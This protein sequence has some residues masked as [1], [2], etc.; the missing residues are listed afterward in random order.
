QPIQRGTKAQGGQVR[1]CQRF[2]D[3]RAMGVARVDQLEQQ[4]LVCQVSALGLE[5]HRFQGGKARRP[6]VRQAGCQEGLR[7][8]E[9]AFKALQAG[10]QADYVG[11]MWPIGQATVQVIAGLCKV[12][13]FDGPF[14][15]SKLRQSP[16]NYSKPDSHGNGAYQRGQTY[17]GMGPEP[18]MEGSQP[19]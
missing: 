15:C 11:I 3:P 6:V 7:G 2:Q 16:E 18:V 9:V 4:S 10:G 17:P 19:Q 5:E 8:L 13:I 1:S 12:P 14:R